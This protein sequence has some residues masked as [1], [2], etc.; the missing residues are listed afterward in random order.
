MGDCYKHDRR[1][2]S[3]SQ[4]TFNLSFAKF[5]IPFFVCFLFMASND[6]LKLLLTR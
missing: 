3:I 4:K 5:H 2:V 6:S 1:N